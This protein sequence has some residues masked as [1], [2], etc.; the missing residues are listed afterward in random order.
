MCTSGLIVGTACPGAWLLYER[1]RPIRYEAWLLSYLFG[2]LFAHQLPAGSPDL[3]FCS[4]PERSPQP[5]SWA[6]SLRSCLA[7]IA[8]V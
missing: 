7:I 4:P 3:C 5:G 1:Y 8:A 6:S 2:A